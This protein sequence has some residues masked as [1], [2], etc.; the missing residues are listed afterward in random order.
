MKIQAELAAV[1]SAKLNLL[2]S[3]EE[4]LNNIAR[5]EQHVKIQEDKEAELTEKMK[6]LSVK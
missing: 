6:N 5:L 1:T 3:I 2:V 4:A